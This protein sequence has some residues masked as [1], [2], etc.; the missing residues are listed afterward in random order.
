MMNFPKISIIGA[1][2]VAHSL[3]PALL[4]A[5]FHIEWLIAKTETRVKQLAATHN[6]KWTI[7]PEKAQS[8]IV[9]IAV[10]DS[11]L[12]KVARAIPQKADRMVFHTTGSQNLATIAGF[13][14]NAGVLYPLQTFSAQRIIDFREIPLCIESSNPK[15]GKTLAYIAEKLSANVHRINSAERLKIHTA[16]VFACNFTNL[17]YT[18]SSDVLSEN[19]LDFN[20]LAPLIKETA[21][22]ASINKPSEVQTG[23]AIRQDMVTIE[24]HVQQLSP[25]LA[26]KYHQLSEWIKNRFIFDYKEK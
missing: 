26:E 25:D 4:A 10:S 11:A 16:A 15:T 6:L 1:G 3:V 8:D 21:Q 18:F 2:N 20:I 14:E 24:K 9:I 13:H 23:P 12:P 22:K 19:D 5:E 7:H 17:M